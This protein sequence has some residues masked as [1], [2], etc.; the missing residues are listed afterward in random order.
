MFKKIVGGLLG[1]AM[2]VSTTTGAQAQVAVTLKNDYGDMCSGLRVV[3]LN[4]RGDG[5][6]SVRSGPST[7]YRKVGELYNGNYVEGCAYSNGW[8]GVVYGRGDCRTNRAGPY[9]GPC[10]SGWVS[11]RYVKVVAG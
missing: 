9:R 11:G 2:F 1:A 6:L 7:R 3:G 10:R 8:H 4:P 5:F